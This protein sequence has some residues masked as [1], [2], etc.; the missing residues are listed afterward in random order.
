MIIRDTNGNEVAQNVQSIKL[1][2]GLSVSYDGEGEATI[3][4]DGL[5]SPVLA[6]RLTMG[7]GAASEAETVTGIAAT[8]IVIATIVDNST[9]DNVIL[10]EAK[11]S[12]NTLT[13]LF[14]EDPGA[15]VV[16]SYAVF[17]TE[18]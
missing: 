6:G 11:P 1:G 12:T 17:R 7:G 5:F 16:V 3:G 4:T 9:N 15:N 13:F 8:D 14:N 2:A 10:L 18:A